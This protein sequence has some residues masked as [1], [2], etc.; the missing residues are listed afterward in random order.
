MRSVNFLGPADRKQS[1]G[2]VYPYSVASPLLM[3]LYRC[4]E[5]FGM[6]EDEK[7][8]CESLN[9]AYRVQRQLAMG[10]GDRCSP[11]FHDA[12]CC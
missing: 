4:I 6:D 5:G 11:V 1:Q 12:D 8:P 10:S 9:A 3:D 2:A 7:L